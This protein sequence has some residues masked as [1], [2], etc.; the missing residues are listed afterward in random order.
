MLDLIKTNDPDDYSIY[1][2]DW[3]KTGH[4]NVEK[5]LRDGDSR[6]WK[7]IQL[8]SIR[9]YVFRSNSE[10]KQKVHDL[11]WECGKGKEEDELLTRLYRR[12]IIEDNLASYHHKAPIHMWFRYYVRGII[13]KELKKKNKEDKKT[14][15]ENDADLIYDRE[16]GCGNN[17]VERNERYAFGQKCFGELW[18]SHPLQAYVLLLREKVGLS[19]KRV[20]AL[21]DHT[22]E[23]NVNQLRRRGMLELEKIA[24]N[25]GE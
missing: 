6:A 10:L 9:F 16:N 12:M 7:F 2:D 14:L 4:R 20:A 25:M 3:E 11:H 5:A 17:V 18:R 8:Y 24:K 22:T 13:T 19:S 15:S 21:L 1:L 23:D